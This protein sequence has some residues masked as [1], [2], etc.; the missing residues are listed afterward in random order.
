MIA[1]NDI[2]GENFKL[3]CELIYRIDR[4]FEIQLSHHY[5]DLIH[6]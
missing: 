6:F 1:L 2:S 4:S 5:A 3:N